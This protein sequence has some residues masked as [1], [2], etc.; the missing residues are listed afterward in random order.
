MK[1]RIHKWGDPISL[2]RFPHL[3]LITKIRYGLQMFLSTKR[4]DWRSLD[5]IDARTWIERWAGREAYDVLW[6]RLFDLK[7]FEF[8]GNLS[9]AWIWTRIKRVGTSRRSLFQEELGYID[10]GS[11]TLVNALCA[12]IIAR[13]GRIHLGHRAERVESSNGCVSGVLSNGRLM[14]CDALISTIPIPLIPDL[15]PDLSPATRNAYALIPNIGVVC[16]LVRLAQS[17]SP[18]FW[19]NIVDPDIDIPGI[20]EFSRLR[21]T[22]DH[23]VYVPYYMPSTHGKWAWSDAQFREEVIGYLLK[24]NPTL[25]RADVLDVSVGRLRYAQPV[26]APEFLKILPPIQT[27][28]IG[29]QI[30]ETCFYYPEDRG[31]A[32]SI[33]LAELMVT[34]LPAAGL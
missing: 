14:S 30:A 32:E 13:G 1:G 33:R 23:I 4:S 19:L 3:S 5:K 6:R 25:S 18:H 29:L 31:I 22:S 16:V 8:A 17:V 26:C 21:R 2:L 34:R 12:A 28:I 10:G 7:F 24:L 9:A 15:V 27:E 20:I 11:Q